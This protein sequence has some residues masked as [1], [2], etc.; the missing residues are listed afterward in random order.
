VI[1]IG[2]F[3]VPPAEDDAFLAA[4]EQ[5]GDPAAT[6]YRALRDDVDFRF[7]E[8]GEGGGY[9]VVREDGAPDTPGGVVLINPFEVPEG[10]D[11]RFLAGWDRARDTLAQQRGYLGTRLHRATGAADFRFVNLAR[12]SS[13]LM[14]ARA[15]QRPQFREAAAAIPFPSHPALYQPVGS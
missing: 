2:L 10:D 4:W 12:W 7:A 9:E 1:A 3:A 5:D 11:E 14:F 6:L 15:L 13:P 8:I